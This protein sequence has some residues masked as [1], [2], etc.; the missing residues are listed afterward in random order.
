MYHSAPATRFNNISPSSRSNYQL[1]SMRDFTRQQTLQTSFI[2][3]NHQRTL[4]QS[5]SRGAALG[6]TVNGN[7]HGNG[8]EF[9]GN[10]AGDLLRQ[11]SNPYL[12][13]RGTGGVVAQSPNGAEPGRDAKGNGSGNNN[14]SQCGPPWREKLRVSWGKPNSGGSG[15]STAPVIPTI[16]LQLIS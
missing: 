7:G 8:L 15:T 11:N 3:N 14:S 9:N 4:Q 10:G 12:R 1:Q 6:H 5:Q 16:K 2:E 13:D